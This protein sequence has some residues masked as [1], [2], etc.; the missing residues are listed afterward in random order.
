M[1]GLR[2]LQSVGI[3]PVKKAF[4]TFNLKSLVAPSDGRA[5]ENIKTQPGPTG[6][7]PTINSTMSFRVPLPTDPLYCPKLVCAVYDYIF[8]G[9]NQ[10]LIG[11]FTIPIGELI[12]TL[13]EE[14]EREIGVIRKITEELDKIIRG[15]SI[16]IYKPQTSQMN[17]I[18]D[19]GS[20]GG[21]ES[22][23]IKREVKP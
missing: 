22:T 9:I 16:P 19:G 8:K 17:S 5:L 3:L 18:N 4:V 21:K 23:S 10:P 2:D 11:T 6:A 15:E 12:Y 14:R 7:N 20:S 1:L 13:R